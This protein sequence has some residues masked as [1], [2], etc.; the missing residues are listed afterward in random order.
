MR[1]CFAKCDWLKQL[2]FFALDDDLEELMINGSDKIFVFH[3]KFGMCKLNI[4]LEENTI[5]VLIKRVAFS[6]G[7]TFDAK[8]P[9]LDT[10]LPDGS[11]VNAVIGNLSKFGC[12]LL[13]ENFPKFL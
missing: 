6:S 12:H 5:L 7:K 3:R 8:N 4:S 13:L 9:I 2:A 11:R 1:V 10:R